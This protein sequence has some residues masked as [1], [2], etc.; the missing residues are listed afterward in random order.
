MGKMRFVEERAGR[1]TFE[2]IEG[3]ARPP[4]VF[5]TV[6]M[7]PPDVY[8][9]QE[10]N[11]GLVQLPNIDRLGAEGIT[12]TNAFANSP[13]CGPSR[14]SY[15]TGRYPYIL[16]NEERRHESWEIELRRDDIIFPEYLKAVGYIVKH[17]GKSHV[18]TAKFTDV[19]GETD[20][21]WN[22]WAPPMTDDDGYVAHL[23]GLGISAP[24]CPHPIRAEHPH[25]RS[26]GNT[27]GGFV[28]QADG[29]PFPE[30]GTYPHYLARL[31]IERLDAALEQGVKDGAPLY[32]QVDFFAPHQPFMIPAGYEKRVEE[33]RRQ[34]KIPESFFDAQKHD[35][36]RLPG[37]P[38]IY[39]LYRR[40]LALYGENALREYI[41]CNFLQMEVVDEAIGKVLAALEKEGLYDRALVIFAA[42][43][44]E[45]NGEKALVDKGVYGHPRVAR[46]PVV[47]KLPGSRNK[48]TSTDTRVCLLDLAPTIL[49]AVG[50]KP[51]ARLDGMSL[52]AMLQAG[53]G[54]VQNQQERIF[55]FEAFW[56]VAPNPAVALEWRKSPSEHYFYTYNLTSDCDEL[57][58]LQDASYRN[59]IGDARYE[60]VRKE[61]VHRLASFLEAD[62]RWRCY[63]HTMRLDKT[64]ELRGATSDYQM[65][66]PQ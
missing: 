26:V 17:V 46:V 21:P 48:G 65:F 30:E 44:G 4:V 52:W 37:E 22:R 8:R 53:S 56:H 11:G 2:E 47:V 66:R 32:L 57:Y 49:D 3:C 13:L 64:E 16:C 51:C 29:S 24:V 41:V 42:D 18:G 7:V 38:K 43:H 50:V 6:D 62:P 9:P 25:G 20:V 63:W 60:E 54:E 55:L 58:D 5:I 39:E 33:L 40:T 59:L 31:A 10:L 23:K 1:G 61:M 35:F 27:F 19:F 28:T 36:G 45:M 34:V 14:A 12:F 15:L